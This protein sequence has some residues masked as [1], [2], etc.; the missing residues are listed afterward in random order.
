[1]RE[2]KDKCPNAAKHTPCPDGYMEWQEWA[3]RMHSGGAKQGLC[4]GCGLYAI[5]TA[6]RK[7]VPVDRGR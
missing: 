1:M 7:P 2:L 5:W 6:P 3:H 4:P